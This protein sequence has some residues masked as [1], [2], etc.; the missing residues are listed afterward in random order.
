M[1]TPTCEF[2]ADIDPVCL[3]MAERLTD[4]GW[5]VQP[6]FID[7]PLT[8][9]LREQACMAWRDGEFRHAGV[10]HGQSFSIQPSLRN[11][12]VHWLNP[13]ACEGAFAQYFARMESLRT[14][15]NR[16]LYLGLFD[17]EAHLS[18]YPP[19]SFYRK[20]LDQFRGIGLRTLTTTLYLNAD[21]RAA[22]GGQLR[23]YLDADNTDTHVDILPEAG[24]LV[25]FL[26]ADFL[27][28]VL[29]AQRERLSVTGWFRRRA[30]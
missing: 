27:H 6:G 5:C 10:G 14:I 15:V 2:D 29:P 16:T 20:H 19:G 3:A 9:A 21:W 30:G 28:E 8:D 24:T 25:C 7:P 18:I 12:R 1:L 26:S 22:D 11:D 13:T 4:V 17:Y 23:L